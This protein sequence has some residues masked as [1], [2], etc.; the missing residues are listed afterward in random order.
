MQKVRILF[1]YGLLV[2]FIKSCM[3]SHVIRIC[4]RVA[5][6]AEEVVYEVVTEPQ[7][8]APQEEVSGESAQ[9][10]THPSVVQ[11]TQGKPWCTSFLFQIITSIFM[12]YYLCIRFRICLEP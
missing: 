10:P 11:Q 2:N 9:G 3:Y 6:A 4:I 1:G 7:G 5:A 8:Q 12:F